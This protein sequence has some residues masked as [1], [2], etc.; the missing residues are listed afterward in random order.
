MSN[1]V[2][3]SKE[4]VVVYDGQAIA[5]ADT[6]SLEVNKAEIDISSLDSEGWAEKL[7]DQKDWSISFD[8][9]VT[10]STITGTTSYDEMTTTEKIDF[11]G[12]LYELKNNDEPVTV[13][14]V[15]KVSGDFYEKGQAFI[16]SLSMSGSNGDKISYSGT[17]T[18]TG[19]LTTETAT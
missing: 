1:I 14:L 12:L 11:D 9:M 10:R 15:S 4:L 8:G 18:G 7:V 6:Y 5:K 3:L 16:T 17:L 19:P 2:K 13:A